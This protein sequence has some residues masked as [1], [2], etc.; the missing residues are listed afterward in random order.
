MTPSTVVGKRRLICMLVAVAAIGLLSI[1]RIQLWIR[2]TRINRP[3][4]VLHRKLPNLDLVILLTGELGNNMAF[5]SHGINIQRTAIEQEKINFTLRFVTQGDGRGNHTRYEFDQCFKHFS[6][7]QVNLAE[8]SAQSSQWQSI[9]ES[10]AR[11]IHRLYPNDTLDQL[12]HTNTVEHKK[13]DSQFPRIMFDKNGNIDS[14]LD[15]LL[16]V[17]HRISDQSLPILQDNDYHFIKTHNLSVPFGIS[18]VQSFAVYNQD[19]IDELFTFNFQKPEC[20]QGSPYADETVLHIRGFEIETRMTNPINQER[21]LE[22]D[23]TRT[24]KELLGHLKPGD[25]VAVVSRVSEEELISY[26][27][28]LQKRGLVVRYVSNLN[29]VQ[30]FCFLM[31]AS[32]EIV[33]TRQSTFFRWAAMLNRQVQNVVMYCLNHTK[34]PCLSQWTMRGYSPMSHWKTPMYQLLETKK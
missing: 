23:P 25:K 34:H 26:M 21:F 17:I 22:L 2:E 1:V 18:H 33:G 3:P 32:K 8:W 20:C 7:D 9:V 10:Q 12:H 14:T 16:D 24:A 31:T 4:Q 30:T 19:S 15:L 28:E 5:I 27:E 11:I 29:G 6:A 13:Y